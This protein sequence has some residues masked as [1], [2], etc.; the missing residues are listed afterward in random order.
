MNRLNRL[1]LGL[2]RRT[3]ATQAIQ[4]KKEWE[5]LLKSNTDKLVSHWMLFQKKK[6]LWSANAFFSFKTES[7]MPMLFVEF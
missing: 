4:N 6:I 7:S 1:S 2:T 5:V 3:F